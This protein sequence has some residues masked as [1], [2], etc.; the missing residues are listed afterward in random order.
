M[1]TSGNGSHAI[2]LSK[3]FVTSKTREAI[4]IKSILRNYP[5]QNFVIIDR[6]SVSNVER[7]SKSRLFANEEMIAHNL[8]YNTAEFFNFV[9]KTLL[10][11]NYLKLFVANFF[12][13]AA[14]SLMH[15]EL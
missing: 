14:V 9:V 1:K 13:T 11:L 15:L 2:K 10:C 3:I 7:K 12:V 6:A 8:Q 5:S 4:S